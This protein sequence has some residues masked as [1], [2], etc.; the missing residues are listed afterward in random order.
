MKKDSI[1]S[2]TR[3]GATKTQR[4]LFTT[5]QLTMAKGFMLNHQNDDKSA[6]DDTPPSRKAP[7]A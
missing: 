3:G 5:A 6:A 2:S 1:S 4:C 7:T